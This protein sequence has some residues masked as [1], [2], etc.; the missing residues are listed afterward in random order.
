MNQSIDENDKLM[1]IEED[2]DELFFA[3]EENDQLAFVDRNKE[4]HQ[5]SWKILIVDDEAEIHDV[6]KLALDD[7]IFED[8]YLNFFSAYSGEEAKQ[9]IQENPD[10]AMILLDVIMEN[11][12]AGLELVQYVREILGNKLVQIILRT[13]QPGQIPEKTVIQEYDING[14]KTKTELTRIKLF[15]IVRTSLK[16]YSALRKERY[17]SERLEKTLKQL[18]EI[19][20][21]LI[22]SEKMSVIGH[23]VAGVAHEINNPL[24]FI[25]GNIQLSIEYIKDILSLLD[26]YQLE[27]P[28]I[29]TVIQNKI[30]DID[31]EYIRND[32]PK[33]I[34]SM[35]DGTERIFNIS[36]SLRTFSRSD[37]ENKI[38]FNLQDGLD[39]TII[40]L[41]HRLKASKNRPEIN[42]YKDYGEIPEIECF[43]GQLNQVFMN[44]FANAIDALEES[45]Q[46]FS[47]EQIKN[48]PNCITIS[49][50]WEKV[51]KS[52]IVKIKDNGVGIPEEVKQRIFENFFTTKAV[53]KG[54][55]LGL[56]IA[57]KIITQNH[58][59]IIEI[60]SKI[61]EGTE[62]IITIP[63]ESS[64][65]K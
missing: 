64:L 65:D 4:Q 21:Q 25:N 33:L 46:G 1:V 26:L 18:K 19:Q 16:A 44:L 50:R 57:N 31:L 43:P 32:L 24:G 58:K 8:K 42:I 62:F 30:K 63:A 5:G 60:N 41:K 28:N 54:T 61:G 39:S 6:T 51:K 55:G 27:F 53:G 52:V 35:E 40:I 22:Q 29:P 10:I 12:K 56:F 13:G 15:T 9:I 38:F 34:A 36:D 2:N 11:D 49:T 37:R 59:G 17:K 3:D 48:N 23:L 7:F 47:Y 20:F 14:Y 45:N